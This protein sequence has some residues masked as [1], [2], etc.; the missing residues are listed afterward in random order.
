[1][2]ISHKYK[3]IFLKT[4]KTA[5]SS[6][7]IFL[8]QFCDKDDILTPIGE[9]EDIRTKQNT[10]P[11]NYLN[12][13]LSSKILL[14]MQNASKPI[15]PLIKKSS[16]LRSL[17]SEKVFFNHMTGH[18][19]REKI[20]REIWNS[21]YKFC[22]ERNP[23]EKLVSGYFWSNRGAEFDELLFDDYFNSGSYL[24]FYDYPIYTYQDEVIVDFIGKYEN[25]KEDLLKV[26]NK[27]GIEFDGD[28]PKSKAKYRPKNHHYSYYYNDK[29]RELVQNIFK[30]EIELLG[31]TFENIEN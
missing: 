15:W 1:M 19:V 25:L 2:I 13:K 24:N 14:L 4:Q 21:Y 22:F 23:W 11:Q 16:Y 9:G 28:L 17:K 26:C 18:E 6:I 10:S 5:G 8:S 20:G 31:Y 7:E 27:I 12:P 3:F 29:N 30:K